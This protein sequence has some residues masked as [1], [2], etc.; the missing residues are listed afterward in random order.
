MKWVRDRLSEGNTWQGL[1]LAG[2]GACLVS[3]DLAHEMVL[4]LQ[5]IREVFGRL[6]DAG[7][8]GAALWLI[9]RPQK[10]R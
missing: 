10:P 4:R 9:L 7:A 5:G 1:I 6:A 8:G 2:I 3:P